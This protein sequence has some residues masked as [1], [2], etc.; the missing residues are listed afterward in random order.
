MRE[1]RLKKL[2]VYREK[3]RKLLIVS[4]K[5]LRM[6]RKLKEKLL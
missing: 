3:L 4:V 2:S 6:P 1:K 5:K